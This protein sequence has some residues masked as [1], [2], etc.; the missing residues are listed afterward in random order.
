MTNRRALVDQHGFPLLS[1]LYEL[2]PHR[3]YSDNRDGTAVADLAGERL[4]KYAR[5]LEQNHDIAKG[6]LDRLVQFTV[7]A[8]GI[9]I[10]PVPKTLDGEIHAEFQAD[11]LEAWRD[12]AQ[13]PEVTWELDWIAVQRLMCRSWLRDGECLAQLII[14]PNPT[15]D[16]GTRVPFSLEL[17]EADLLPFSH[18]DPAR[19][20]INGVERNEWN[21]PRAYWLY[22]RHPGGRLPTDFSQKRVP[23]E[24]L[25]HL[26]ITDRIGQVRGVS[27]F[28]SV[29]QRMNDLYEYET[30]ERMAAR[31]AAN[32]TG[33]LKTEAPEIYTPATD[34]NGNPVSR[35]LNLHPGMILDN[36]RPGESLDIV[37]SNRPSPTLEPFRNGQLRAAAAGLGISYSA[38]AR[39]YNGSYSAQRQEL[40]ESGAHYAALSRL[41]I[42]QFVRPVWQ[43]FVMTALQ[44]GIV[45]AP[46]DTDP[47]SLDDAEFQPPTLPWIDPQKMASGQA[48]M[49]ENFL[50]SPQQLIRERGENPVEILNQ[51]QRWKEMLKERG[52]QTEPKAAEPM[53]PQQ[54]E[55]EPDP[56]KETETGTQQK[57]ENE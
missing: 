57:D 50:S 37:S 36:L 35:D 20:I 43:A 44:A 22:K 8:S 16:H 40:V 17:L 24:R 29:L 45:T 15:L 18:N 26:K 12:W 11:L 41:Y 10:E 27:V 5:H 34:A 49:M 14:G 13:W 56:E 3:S 7:G 2:K 53:A 23:S 46:A 4:R 30:A 9:G 54:A 47:R 1:N 52:L 48:L 21:R 19:N 39:D 42:N 25:L 28:A 51:W 55:P 38:L 33:V 6:A 31:I 32:F